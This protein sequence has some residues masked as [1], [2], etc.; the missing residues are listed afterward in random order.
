MADIQI[1]NPNKI[2]EIIYESSRLRY[3]LSDR[4][5][6]PISN[7]QAVRLDSDNYK[8]DLYTKE[9]YYRFKANGLE[10]VLTTNPDT[11]S[12]DLQFDPALAQAVYRI[13][14]EFINTPTED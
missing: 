11:M 5:K 12:M 4:Y 14:E 8:I 7:I 1:K 6:L 10:N 3:L 9:T 2:Q 13:I